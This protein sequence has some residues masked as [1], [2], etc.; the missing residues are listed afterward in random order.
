MLRSFKKTFMVDSKSYYDLNRL[1]NS[2]NLITYREEF[3]CTSEGD[4]CKIFVLASNDKMRDII[5]CI[6]E[7][8]EVRNYRVE[9]GGRQVRVW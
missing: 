6:E 1:L 7:A 3:L 8:I 5:G 9:L 4:Y 2:F